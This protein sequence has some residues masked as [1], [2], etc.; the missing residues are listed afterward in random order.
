MGR[1]RWGGWDG[2]D[3]A[4]GMDGV[5]GVDG[6]NGVGWMGW[7]GLDE[8]GWMAEDLLEA[9]MVSRMN[10]GFNSGGISGEGA[11]FGRD[12]RV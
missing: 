1:M 4:D 6:E 7:D 10:K 8:L 5:G 3:R 12:L 9:V 11:D 2:V